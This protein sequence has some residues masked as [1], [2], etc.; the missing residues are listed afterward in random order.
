MQ[1]KL[2]IMGSFNELY[3]HIQFKQYSVFIFLLFS[4]SLTNSLNGKCWTFD[5]YF[6]VKVISVKLITLENFEWT[7]SQMNKVYLFLHLNCCLINEC[8]STFVHTH[9]NTHFMCK[10]N[11]KSAQY[12]FHYRC[13]TGFWHLFCLWYFIITS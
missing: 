12:S 3:T 13:T 11:F 8:I 1:H 5:T 2:Y 10:L 9:E 7:N 6:K 4:L